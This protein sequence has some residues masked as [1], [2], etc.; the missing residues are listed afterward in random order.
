MMETGAGLRTYDGY[1]G[2]RGPAPVGLPT[3]GSMVDYLLCVQ[4]SSIMV[5]RGNFWCTIPVMSAQLGRLHSEI[6]AN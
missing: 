1:S 6:R 5:V 2:P 3:P 4:V